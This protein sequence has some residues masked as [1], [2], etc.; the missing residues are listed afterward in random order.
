MNILHFGNTAGMGSILAN[1]DKENKHTIFARTGTDPFGIGSFYGTKT[2]DMHPLWFVLK[3]KVG[4]K[5]DAFIIRRPRLAPIIRLFNRKAIIII[6]HHGTFLREHSKEIKLYEKYADHVV[7]TTKDLLV[8]RPNALWLP[9]PVDANHFRP[10]GGPKKKLLVST[11]DKALI[12]GELA[13]YDLHN[14]SEQPIPYSE[15]P[16]F[17]NGYECLCNPKKYSGQH[18]IDSKGVWSGLELQA[19]AC[20]LRVYHSGTWHKG[21]PAECRPEHYIKQFNRL[22]V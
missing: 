10:L 5:W 6:Y 19:F 4:R 17:L 16:S 1:F 14:P 2:R 12:P 7:V 3:N 22:L 18:H 9:N 13:G 8:F 21:L 15:M 20:G 11:R